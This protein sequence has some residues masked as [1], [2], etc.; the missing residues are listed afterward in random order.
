MTDFEPA[1]LKLQRS[2]E[3]AM[4]AR[5]AVARL[6][7]CDLC[8]HMCRV[9]RLA[10]DARSAC[11]VGRKAVVHGFGPHHGEELPLRGTGGSGTIFFSG[12]SLRC[13]FCQ[14]WQ[15][16]QEGVGFD[17]TAA[18]L[19]DAMLRIQ[20]R[21][22]HNVNL[23]SPSH[24]VAQILE[25]LVIAADRGL[26]LPLVYNT[27]GYDSP[28][29]LGLLDGVVDIYMPDMK[30]DDSKIAM[31]H[32]HVLDYVEVNQAAVRE[33]HRQVGDLVLD[34]DGVAQ[35]GLL[36]RHLVLPGDLS[37]TA[38]VLAFIAREI[39]LNTYVNLMEQYRPCY[40]A[41]EHPPLDREVTPEEFAR[42]LES[43][44]RLGLVRLDG[45]A[46]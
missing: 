32:S 25:A 20:A 13:D 43:A 23:V 12:C 42:A 33:M 35:R 38:G 22:C 41:P 11:R 36:V 1:Y 15:T 18:E 26:R 37:G 19:A 45:A 8:A 17:V 27:G 21:G 5:H 6:A 16:S 4:V 2:G 29:A 44:R 30:Y 40:R 31:K 10:P 39:S 24:V 28:E 7:S 3:L 14:N 46:A 34:R 9:N